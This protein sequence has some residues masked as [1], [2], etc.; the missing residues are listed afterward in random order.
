MK[1]SLLP[2]I[3]RERGTFFIEGGTGI[4]YRMTCYSLNSPNSLNMAQC[5]SSFLLNV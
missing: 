4:A 5:G 1:G 2:A 3:R